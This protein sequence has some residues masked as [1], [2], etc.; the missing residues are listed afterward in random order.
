[1]AAKT[2]IDKL[3]AAI[4]EILEDYT[5]Q[6]NDSVGEIA[7]KLAKKGTQTL[8]NVSKAK[9]K[10]GKGKNKWKYAKGWKVEKT[11][12]RRKQLEKSAVIYNE[13]SGLPHLLEYG[14]VTRNGTNRVFDDVKGREHIAPV[15]EKLVE[16]F[17]KEVM[18]K[19]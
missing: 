16:T 12:W 13:Q 2:P 3:G 18:A 17:M 7:E 8:R 1:M 11:D 19:L 4:S 9:F 15:E 14:H 10:T 6:V 5:D